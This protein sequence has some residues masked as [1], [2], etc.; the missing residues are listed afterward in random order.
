MKFNSLQS[1]FTEQFGRDAE[2]AVRAPGRVNLIGE[3]TDYNGGFVL[4]IAIGRQ[5]LACLAGRDDSV[6]TFTS[7]QA[8]ESASIDLSVPI[9][10]GEPAWANYCKGVAAGL[11]A[12]GI[13]LRGA[14]ILFDSDIPIGAGLSSSASLEVCTALALLAAAGETGT[15]PD[16]EIALLCQQ[17][18]NQYAGA[19]CGIMDQSIC[20]MARAGHAMLLDCRSGQAEQVPFAG[21]DMVLLVA[22]TQ[23]RHDI[24]AGQYASRRNEC[25]AAA[26][27]LGLSSLR[28]A[29]VDMIESAS[30]L[31]AIE[32][33]RARHVVSENARTLAAV[34][35]LK[36]NEYERFG[37]LMYESH[38]SLKSDFE[39]SC[40]E[41][42]CIVELAKGC[43]GV[44]GARMTGGGFGG[45]AI[46]L[47]QSA[48][49]E[50]I[51][52]AVLSGFAERFAR[53]CSI[54][55]TIAAAG[56]GPIE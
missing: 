43:G 39:V 24:A 51:S 16:G 29:D 18:E 15:L 44:Y 42:D 47:A 46:I 35:A 23:V 55:P 17:A 54:F 40:D 52:A 6:I 10:P 34:D 22:D 14:D 13:E 48:Q 33:N 4:P 2:L 36:A 21:E 49:A 41:L 32:A 45:C 20:V 30:E 28:D 1:R 50:S 38:A 53:A 19:P 12:R 56:G 9:Q 11:A 31:T 5:S 7:L 27:K 3:H 26:E 8:D 25:T 37:E